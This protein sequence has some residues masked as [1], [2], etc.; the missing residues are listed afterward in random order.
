L[1]H[2]AGLRDPTGLGYVGDGNTGT[3]LSHLNVHYTDPTKA[4]PG[5]IVVF[6]S[7]R[8]LDEQHAAMVHTRG[9]DPILFTHGTAADPSL[10]RLSQLQPG[11][12]GR[13]VFCGVSSL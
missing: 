12:P 3:F 11:F 8:P 13:T 2:L 10:L 6:N 1:C 9:R 5:A 7:D 4:L